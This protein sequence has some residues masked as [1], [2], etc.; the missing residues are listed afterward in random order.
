MS[1][2]PVEARKILQEMLTNERYVSPYH[3]AMVHAGFGEQDKAF[4]GLEKALEDREGRMSVLK[5]APEFD[6]LHS[7]RRFEEIVR[8]VA[9]TQ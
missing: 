6:G 8:R 5:F 2:R 9:K 4:E 7:D 3:L 1:G